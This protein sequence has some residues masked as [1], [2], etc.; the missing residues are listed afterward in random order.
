[1]NVNGTRVPRHVNWPF[2]SADRIQ[3]VLYTESDPVGMDCSKILGGI[4]LE[5]K[6]ALKALGFSLIRLGSYNLIKYDAY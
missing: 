4:I 6:I 2:L 3:L 5:L 1:M